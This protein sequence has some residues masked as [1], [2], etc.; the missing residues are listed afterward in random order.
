M[1]LTP[2]AHLRSNFQ[3]HKMYVAQK[4]KKEKK[5]T[6]KTT[7]QQTEKNPTDKNPQQIA[8]IRNQ[9]THIPMETTMK[10]TT[11][12]TFKTVDLFD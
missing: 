4:K 8:N 2:G 12:N 5:T 1:L 3:N 6:N 10:K 11:L 7:I 9:T